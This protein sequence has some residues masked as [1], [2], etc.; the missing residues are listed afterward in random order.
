MPKRILILKPSSLGDV[1]HALP[2]LTALRHLYPESKIVWMV[3]EEWAEMLEGNP[4]LNEIMPV[5][6]GLRHWPSLI[7]RVRQGQFDLVVDLQGLFRTGLL[8]LLTG[9]MTRIGFAKGREGS[10]WFYTDRIELP[11]PMNRSWRLLDM[12]AVDRNL[13]VAKYLGA[14]VS[15]PKF[16]IPQLESDQEE[17]AEWLRHADVQPEDRLIAIA[18]LS[19]G[20]VKCWPLD[21]FVALAHEISQWTACK[22]VLLGSCSQEWIVEKFDQIRA[23]GLINMVGKVRIRQL[24]ILL[25][26]TDLLI[27]NDSAPIH[28]AAAVGIPVLGIFGPTNAIA[29]GP[30]G[31]SGHRVMNAEISCRPCGKR[32]CHQVSQKECLT[33]ITVD[34]VVASARMLLNDSR[35]YRL[36][37]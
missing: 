27:A 22:I 5:N 37:V 16:W 29:T 34:D 4:Y 12:H 9:A 36:P 8:A 25:R 10:P 3:K 21:R 7:R 32:S 13:T 28:I 19:R 17:V 6:F 18:P 1:I 30:Y 33:A 15:H 14:N 20:E 11:L 26:Q 35:L 2:T 23:P 24:G 31:N